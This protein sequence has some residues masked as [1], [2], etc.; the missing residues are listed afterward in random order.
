M[1][2]LGCERGNERGPVVGRDRLD[3]AQ[4]PRGRDEPGQDERAARPFTRA[5]AAAERAGKPRQRRRQVDGFLAGGRM[6][7]LLRRNLPDDQQGQAGLQV[8]PAAD[9][10]GEHQSCGQPFGAHDARDQSERQSRCRPD[11]DEHE[12]RHSRAP[13]KLVQ[14]EGVR[15]RRSR[16]R[17]TR[18]DDVEPTARGN[19]D[20]ERE[21]GCRRDPSGPKHGSAS[22]M[23]PDTTARPFRATAPSCVRRGAPGTC[24]GCRRQ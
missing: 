6:E 10:E 13:G 9:A 22:V 24:V 23:P 4:R 17:R 1:D 11:S 8:A 7:R 5:R 20:A 19:D 21:Q 2:V 12:Q 3:D 18:L 16:Q 14:R 15:H